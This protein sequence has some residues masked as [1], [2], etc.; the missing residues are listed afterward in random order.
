MEGVNVYILSGYSIICEH[1]TYRLFIYT[2]TYIYIYICKD[3][4]SLFKLQQEYLQR[5]LLFC[6]KILACY[7]SYMLDKY[8][9]VLI[10]S[11]NL[12]QS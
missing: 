6:T 2:Y 1:L 3:T 8:I 4:Y 9:E 7:N 11:L 10:E 5:Q 12:G